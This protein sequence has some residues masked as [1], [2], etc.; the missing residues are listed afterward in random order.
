M[1]PEA[2]L[3]FPARVLT[4]KQREDYFENGYALVESLIPADVIDHLNAVTA[5]FI[6]KS[7]S[8]TQSS[9]DLDIGPGHSAERPIVRRLISPDRM[10]DAYWDFANG[11]IGDAAA[12]LLGPDV[13]FN[14]SKLN[15]KWSDGRDQV[16]WHQDIPFYPHTNYNV[17]AI[18]CYLTD[19]AEQ[20]GPIGIIP[21]SHKGPIFEH[22][23]DRGVWTGSMRDTDMAMY[24]PEDAVYLPG[25]KGSITIHHSR[26]VHGSKPTTQAN[27][28][29]LLI[30][31]YAAADAFPYTNPKASTTHH[32][33]D[34]I[35]GERATWA[36]LDPEPCPIPP[37]WGDGYTTIY[38]HQ[39]GEDGE[40]T[41]RDPG[42]RV[43]AE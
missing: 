23:D 36:H 8:L 4:Q 5:E 24:E 15:F 30:N 11:I 26:A 25:P 34:L 16:K 1:T 14:H 27:G 43:A 19:V 18:G 10:H 9:G 28:R 12:D 22:F 29:P 32:Y 38:A 37:D 3:A 2:I 7:R 42:F 41:P 39:G 13:T 33:R 35:R 21:G 31:A 20:D 40:A 17:L 6:E